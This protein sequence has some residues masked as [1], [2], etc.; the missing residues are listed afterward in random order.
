[1]Y[2]ITKILQFI[3]WERNK[4]EHDDGKVHTDIL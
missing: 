3:L 4:E 1:M 2:G